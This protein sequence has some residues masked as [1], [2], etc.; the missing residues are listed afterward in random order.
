MNGV[1]YRIRIGVQWR[2]LPERYG[3]WKT[4]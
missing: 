2:D 4:V 1:L 3:P